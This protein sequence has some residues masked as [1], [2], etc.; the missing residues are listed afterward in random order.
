MPDAKTTAA[1][2]PQENVCAAAPTVLLVDD[3]DVNLKVLE[4][5]L[6]DLACR[7]LVAKNGKEAVAL[8]RENDVDLI[9]MDIAMPVMDGLEATKRI[10]T[11]EKKT[12]KHTPIIAVTA[13]IKPADQHICINSGTNDYL[14]K[15]VSKGELSRSIKI[16]APHICE[17]APLRRAHA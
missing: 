10:R 4:L 3:N 1:N 17:G 13:H 15:P 16:W 2:K 8:F 6:E 14:A 11:L 9:F 5:Y 12:G 7:F